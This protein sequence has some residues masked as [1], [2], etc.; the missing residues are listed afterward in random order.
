MKPALAGSRLGI[1]HR[2]NARSNLLNVSYK[3]HLLD[4]GLVTGSTPKIA[5]QFFGILKVN[6]LDQFSSKTSS[7]YI[8]LNR[9]YVLYPAMLLVSGKSE[10]NGSRSCLSWQRQTGAHV[11]AIN[12]GPFADHSYCAL[13][14]FWQFSQ[15]L[16]VFFVYINMTQCVQC[17]KYI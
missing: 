12:V 4:L 13:Q 15:I 3:M 10:K 9:R 1:T 5:A 14:M 8:F 11:L 6:Y 7:V 17:S 2:V 16:S